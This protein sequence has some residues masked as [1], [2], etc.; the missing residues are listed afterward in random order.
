MSASSAHCKKLISGSA[1]DQKG[2]KYAGVAGHRKAHGTIGILQSGEIADVNVKHTGAAGSRRGWSRHG[3]R[4]PGLAE[5]RRRRSPE[6]KNFHKITSRDP[7]I[8]AS[9]PFARQIVQ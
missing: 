1:I 8:R 4:K 2:I 6:P 5:Q 7:G 9:E 3:S